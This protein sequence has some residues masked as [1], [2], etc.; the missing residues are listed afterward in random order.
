MRRFRKVH[1][2]VALVAL[3]AVL[4]ALMSVG[5]ALNSAVLADDDDVVVVFSDTFDP[6]PLGLSRFVLTNWAVTAGNVDVI[7]LGLFDLYPGNGNYLDMDGSA[8]PT[9]A[10]IVSTPLTLSPGCYQLSFE[11]GQNAFG[12]IQDN[13]L[14]VT[15]GAVF[16]GFFA[17][18]VP[19][20][21]PATIL[22]LNTAQ[23]IVPGDDDD[24]PT[25]AS[26]AFSETGT[27]TAGGSVL[28]DVLLVLVD[29]DGCEVDDDEVDDDEVDDDEVDDDE[30]DDDEVDD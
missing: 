22:T 28:D 13:G 11:M 27:P 8:A 18:P 10:T 6:E 23:I 4:S 16:A 21:P 2:M 26:L 24:P 14:A 29:D 9:N 3:V 1:M 5:V 25:V 15:L 12:G 19:P 17:A 20:S 30:V 7:G